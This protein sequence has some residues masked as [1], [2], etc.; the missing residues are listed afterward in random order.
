M[1]RRELEA[2]GYLV[3]PGFIDLHAHLREPGFEDSETIASGARAALRGGFTTICAM[4]NTEPAIDSPGLVAEVIARGRAAAGARVLPIATI[5]RGRNGRELA[6]V[7]ELA[8]AGAVAFSDDG[9]P[10]DDARLFR[11]ALEYARAKDLLI[12]EHAQDMTLSGKGVMH[13]GVVSAR[14]GLPGIPSAAEETAVARDIAIAEMTGAR[15]HL[16]HISTRGAIASIR[17][18]KSGGLR[19]TCDVTPHHLAMTD[20]WVAGDRAFAWER[21]GSLAR[22]GGPAPVRPVDRS[23]SSRSRPSLESPP[24]PLATPYDSA[25]KVNPPLRG[26]SDVRALW[27]G[28][29]DGTVDAIAT[30]HAPHASVRKDVEFDQAAFG[31]SGLETALSLVLGGVRAGWCD[32][33]T[34]IRALTTGPAG[35]LGIAPSDDDWIAIDPDLEWIATAESLVSLGKNTPLLGLTLRG[36]VV[37]AVV[38]G[39]VRYEG[40]LRGA[41]PVGSR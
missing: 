20:D 11:H 29:V 5:T 28:L 41:T 3:T 34:V 17:D 2:K 19:I 1:Q 12:I 10:V 37:H 21:G 39:E 31:I 26:W 35:V 36:R 13:E 25:T 4:P 24:A 9:A 32:R 16:T 33:D 27:E 30:D 8:A 22:E 7:M 38:G 23:P 14:L 18:A 40:G 15:L 6:D